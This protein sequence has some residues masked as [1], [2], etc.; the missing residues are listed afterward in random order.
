MKRKFVD[1]VGRENPEE[2]PNHWKNSK[3]Y[4]LLGFPNKL[5]FTYLGFIPSSTGVIGRTINM[6]WLLARLLF[7]LCLRSK[8]SA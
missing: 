1:V 6:G 7:T 8:Y 4:S 5:H 2:Y 3:I